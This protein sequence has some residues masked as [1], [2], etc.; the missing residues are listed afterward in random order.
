EA[1]V[2]IAATDVAVHACK[3]DLLHDLVL[4]PGL[5]LPQG[6][7]ERWALLIDGDG[8]VR[9]IHVAA[10]FDVVERPVLVD[11]EEPAYGEPGNADRDAQG[12]YGIPHPDEVDAHLVGVG[13]AE[14]LGFDSGRMGGVVA[15]PI[16]TVGLAELIG[17]FALQNA[18]VADE[19]GGAAGGVGP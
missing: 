18:A 3:P 16:Q 17:V 9:L 10:E 4:G 11:D 15:T 8:E 2:L 5:L 1:T 19:A 7:R 14:E 13:L 6:G 12:T